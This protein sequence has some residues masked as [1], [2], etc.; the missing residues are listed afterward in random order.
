MHLNK[1]I[2]KVLAKTD[3]VLRDPALGWI[4]GQNISEINWPHT[5][6]LDI[7]IDLSY[8]EKG[9]NKQSGHGHF[10]SP[11][12]NQNRLEISELNLNAETT[13]SWWWTAFKN[14]GVSLVEIDELA[15]VPCQKALLQRVWQFGRVLSGTN[16]VLW[17][18]TNWAWQ[19]YYPL[20]RLWEKPRREGRKEAERR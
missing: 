5:W 8:S 1:M 9:L 3:F 4:M 6:G 15:R 14:Q 20:S 2:T 11:K 10:L 19:A 13:K 17:G 16:R 12:P 7:N 18:F